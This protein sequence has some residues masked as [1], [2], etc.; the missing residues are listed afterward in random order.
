MFEIREKEEFYIERRV[1]KLRST[2]ATR[3]VEQG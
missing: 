1:Q 2:I 3:T